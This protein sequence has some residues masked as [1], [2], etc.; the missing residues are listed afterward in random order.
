[1][2]VGQAP[3]RTEADSGRPFSGSAG[4]TL[5][6]WLA[7]AGIEEER[8][9]GQVYIA[10]MTRCFPGPAPSG[11]GDRRPSPPELALCRGYLSRE[12]ALV[13]PELV[14]LVGGMA[15]EGLLGKG[16]L[17][18]AVGRFHER[19]GVRYLPAAAPLRGE[20][21]EQRAPES[22][23]PPAGDRS[24]GG[25]RADRTLT[26]ARRRL[27]SRAQ[28]A[29]RRAPAG[30]ALPAHLVRGLGHQRR[31][32]RRPA[33]GVEGDED[34]VGA[35]D[36]PGLAGGEILG[37]HPDADLE[38][39]AAGVVDGRLEGHQVADEDRAQ[40]AHL[41]QAGG[42]HPPAAVAHG[43]H[44]GGR[45]DQLEDAASVDVARRVGV[46]RQHELAHRD[47]QLGHP[48]GRRRGRGRGLDGGPGVWH[49]TRI[50]G[51]PLLQQDRP[52]SP[53]RQVESQPSLPDRAAP[54]RPGGAAQSARR[55]APPGGGGRRGRGR[56]AERV[57][58]AAAAPH[59]GRRRGDAGV[60]PLH[61]FL[62]GEGVRQRRPVAGRAAAVESVPVLRRAVPGQRADGGAL[63]ARPAV[64]RARLSARGGRQ[65]VAAP[66]A[67]G[68]RDVRPRPL[69]LG[70]RSRGRRPSAPWPSPG[71]ASSGPTWAT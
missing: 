10:A 71:P 35:A 56:G 12:L 69:G 39:G 45:I 62:P 28:R 31:H 44:A 41:V 17:H 37:L 47:G 34:E 43:D 60:R 46:G 52:G 40:E 7:E 21:L 26:R 63:S 29:R 6:G 27:R 51:R 4:R 33:G 23:P 22:R 42:H 1:M 18:E 25:E 2:M 9:R 32:G 15:I 68:R 36:V 20:S 30:L 61:V 16:P 49:G 8:F 14:V 58:R 48:L 3:G 59:P 24:A 67:R 50:V 57:L 13:Q 65:P 64:R 70:P 38:G 53:G 5:F 55:A 54:Q 19:E 66:L 11:S